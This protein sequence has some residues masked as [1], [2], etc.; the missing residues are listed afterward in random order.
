MQVFSRARRSASLPAL[1]ERLGPIISIRP[2][3]LAELLAN[4]ASRI[5]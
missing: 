1:A 4:C 3:A 5:D 2:E